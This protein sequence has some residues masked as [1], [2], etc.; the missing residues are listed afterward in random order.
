MASSQHNAVDWSTEESF[1][2]NGY[3]PEDY[4]DFTGLPDSGLP[5][6][7]SFNFAA[8]FELNTQLGSAAAPSQENQS[9]LVDWAFD[10]L[11]DML[12]F[13]EQE[14]GIA[15]QIEPAPGR[16]TS[17]DESE[18][19][20]RELEEDEIRFELKRIDLQERRRELRKLPQQEQQAEQLREVED[21][22]EG[23]ELKLKRIEL[24]KRRQLIQKPRPPQEDQRSN[25]PGA[26]VDLFPHACSERRV[27]TIDQGPTSDNTNKYGGFSYVSH[28]SKY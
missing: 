11:L 16:D 2:H 4:P 22:L 25:C 26:Q 17:H 13:E 28:L 3:N 14:T 5:A 23:V 9:T 20:N 18:K 21:E 24:L 10:Y 6:S 15:R 27:S 12:Q 8:S 7:G 19:A 1:F